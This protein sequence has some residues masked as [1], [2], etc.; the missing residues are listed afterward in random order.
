MDHDG[1][2]RPPSVA[3]ETFRLTTLA[4]LLLQSAQHG[5]GRPEE[6]RF[7]SPEQPN[8]RGERARELLD[9][10]LE[11]RARGPGAN[12]SNRSTVLFPKASMSRS[13]VKIQ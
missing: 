9:I 12:S 11:L 4:H 1:P 13:D 6:L 3:A 8:L 7:L 5:S 10:V 2:Y